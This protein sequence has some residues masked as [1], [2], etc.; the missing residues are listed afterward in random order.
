MSGCLFPEV[1]EER[2]V[3]HGNGETAPAHLLPHGYV[4]RGPLIVTLRESGLTGKFREDF[5][6]YAQAGTETFRNITWDVIPHQKFEY[7]ARDSSIGAMMVLFSFM[8]FQSTS[9][10]VRRL[11]QSTNFTREREHKQLREEQII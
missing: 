5:S 10:L 11:S 8:S 9:G 4:G 1:Y 6:Y 7:A 3:D 2:G